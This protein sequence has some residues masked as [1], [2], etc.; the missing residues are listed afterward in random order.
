MKKGN[1]SDQRWESLEE[2]VRSYMSQFYRQP[3]S[4]EQE[5][6][7]PQDDPREATDFCAVWDQLATDP[8]TVH[9]INYINGA[10]VDPIPSLNEIV[11]AFFQRSNGRAIFPAQISMVIA[12]CGGRLSRLITL[13]TDVQAAWEALRS[14]EISRIKIK[15]EARNAD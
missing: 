2:D 4:V 12:I 14:D 11:A 9:I 8:A 15:Q 7:A 13:R 5:P 3:G 1:G 10:V 6:E